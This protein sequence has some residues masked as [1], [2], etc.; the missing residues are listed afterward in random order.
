MKTLTYIAV[1]M[2][3]VVFAAPVT[4]AGTIVQGD[5]ISLQTWNS[6]DA[7]GIMYFH[8]SDNQNMTNSF[9]FSSFCI[10]DDTYI[11]AGTP[12]QIN[13]ISRTVGPYAD[14]PVDPAQP[15]KGEGP[16]VGAVDYLFS[17]Y[18]AGKYNSLLTSGDV[19][20]GMNNY[21]MQENFQRLLWSLQGTALPQSSYVN[22][23]W[24]PWAQDLAKYNASNSAFR[25]QDFGTRVLNI[26]QTSADGN[27]TYDVQNQLCHVPEP[28]FILLLGI[29]LGTLALAWRKT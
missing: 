17:Q 3:F 7:A 25:N 23:S 22:F 20:H 13:N 27:T 18:W 26:T 19:A 4:M 8:V 2:L 21:Q 6:L 29:G 9:E 10:Q 15:H 28:S 16:L 12:F 5:W 24:T 14:N 1:V 11:W